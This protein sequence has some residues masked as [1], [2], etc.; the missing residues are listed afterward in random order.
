[1]VISLEGEAGDQMLHDSAVIITS[2]SRYSSAT[3]MYSLRNGGFGGQIVVVCPHDDVTDA[4]EGVR[5]AA[6]A[7][8][9]EIVHCEMAAELSKAHL[10]NLGVRHTA[11]RYI[12]LSDVDAI[13]CRSTLEFIAGRSEEEVLSYC[14]EVLETDSRMPPTSPML[15]LVV[16]HDGTLVICRETRR[17]R[18]RRPGYGIQAFPRSLFEKI[19]GYDESIKGWGGEDIDFITKA[20]AAGF[21]LS[22]FP[23]LIHVSHSSDGTV[24]IDQSTREKL[25]ID[26]IKGTR[27]AIGSN[28]R[29]IREPVWRF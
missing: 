15:R 1:M 13:W 9:A 27:T 16:A 5:E 10:V 26:R 4:V 12:I 24:P 22:T 7:F 19:G 18:G 11:H 29:F 23:A 3:C 28:R 25:I 17:F 6:I 8:S 14:S 20:Y 2:H 21:E